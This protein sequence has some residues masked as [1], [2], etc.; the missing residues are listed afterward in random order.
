MMQAVWLSLVFI[1]LSAVSYVGL[2]PERT[3]E[4]SAQSN[5]MRRLGG[6]VG[7]S[8]TTTMLQ[9]RLQ[10]HH[11]RLAEHT[12]PYN[13]YDRNTPLAPIDGVIQAQS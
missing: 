10:F 11:A 13:G 3:H 7:V 8:F 4:A 1:P 6:R 5:L 9:K 12:T 2:P